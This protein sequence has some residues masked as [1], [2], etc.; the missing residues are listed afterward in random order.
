[1]RRGL[2][3][4]CL[5]VIAIIGIHAERAMHSG[6]V[7]G[8]VSPADLSSSIV[9]VQGG[10]SVKT[11]SNNGH[12]GMRLQPGLWKLVFVTTRP[13]QGLLERKVNVS[14]GQRVDL[15]EIKFTE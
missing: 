9:A 2:L 5:V 1:M 11:Y 13:Y 3:E 8:R 7:E 4:L 6:S 14:E 12:F 15:G 10:D